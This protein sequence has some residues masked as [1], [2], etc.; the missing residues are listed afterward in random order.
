MAIDL[1]R[2]LRYNMI[3]L[4][5]LSLKF[6]VLALLVELAHFRYILATVIA[7]ETTILHNFSWHTFWTWGDRSVGISLGKVLTRL[8]KFQGCN[9]AVGLLVNVLVVRSLVGALGLHYFVANVAATLVAGLA[10]FLLSE[11]FIFKTVGASDF[12]SMGAKPRAQ[13]RTLL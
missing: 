9:G 10:S 13:H 11:F 7:V 6:C 4:L 8:L 5:G 1:K 12:A 3:G 2:F